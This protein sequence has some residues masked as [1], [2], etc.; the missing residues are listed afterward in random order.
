MGLTKRQRRKR[1]TAQTM[2]RKRRKRK[3]QA[4]V[5]T[6]R[7]KSVEAP[8]PGRTRRK[9]KREMPARSPAKVVAPVAPRRRTRRSHG[10]RT[11]KQIEAN[12]VTEASLVTRRIKTGK[13]KTTQSDAIR[14]RRMIRRKR[15]R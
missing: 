3:M 12:P 13:E 9:R 14:M 1:R 5:K 15:R 8:A 11:K 4:Q 2:K 6:K 7:R 10:R